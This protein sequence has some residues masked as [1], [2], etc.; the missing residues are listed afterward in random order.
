LLTGP[1]GAGKTTIAQSICQNMRRCVHVESDL[2]FH[3]I[4]SGSIE[5]WRPEAHEQ[6]TVVMDVVARVAIG[7]AGAGYPTIVDGILLP[8]WFLEPVRDA[9]HDA[10]VQVSLAILRPSR[11]TVV[12]RRSRIEPSIPAGEVEA[13]WRDFTRPGPPE[14]HSFENEGDRDATSTA[15]VAAWE[16]GQLIV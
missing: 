7:F 14:R 13:M 4:A 5:P 10:G 16:A 2:L 11:E 15:I 6:N 9:L 1:P 3:A 12:S 8:G